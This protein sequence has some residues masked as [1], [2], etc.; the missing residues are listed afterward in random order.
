MDKKLY[1]DFHFLLD[2]AQIVQKILLLLNKLRLKLSKNKE[3]I[4]ALTAFLALKNCASVFRFIFFSIS[5]L[6]N[7]KAFCIPSKWPIWKQFCRTQIA[8]STESRFT[9]IRPK[10]WLIQTFIKK[11]GRFVTVTNI[12]LLQD[13]WSSL[14]FTWLRSERSVRHPWWHSRWKYLRIREGGQYCAIPAFKRYVNSI[15]QITL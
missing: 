4:W 10:L 2:K 5:R 6:F 13:I 3:N 14:E 12:D 15:A 7:I 1:P 8:K 11:L 9:K